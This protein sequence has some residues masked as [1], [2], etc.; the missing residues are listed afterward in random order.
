M[1]RQAW[2]LTILLLA[3]CGCECL[4]TYRVEPELNGTFEV[5]Y[6]SGES[7]SAIIVG[8]TSTAEREGNC[9]VAYGITYDNDVPYAMEPVSLTISCPGDSPIPGAL[10]TMDDD[11]ATYELLDL[12]TAREGETRRIPA[13]LWVSD[14]HYAEAELVVTRA[15]GEYRMAP[16]GPTEDYLREFTMTVDFDCATAPGADCDYQVE[17][18]LAGR[19]T[20]EHF[21]GQCG[22]EP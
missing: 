3:P 20:A 1:T 6:D 19:Q 21:T 4:T 8:T 12:N 15:V 18:S 13:Q 5:R 11:P 9:W 16:E 17:I 14:G 22:T 7:A 10:L 2:A